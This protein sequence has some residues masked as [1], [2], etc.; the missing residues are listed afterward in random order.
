MMKKILPFTVVLLFFMGLCLVP[1]V[2]E[3]DFVQTI[4]EDQVSIP[5]EG[6]SRTIRVAVYNES[7]TTAPAW[8]T[9]PH[10][11]YDF[12]AT[13]A[14]L[15]SSGFDV[16]LL[17]TADILNHE[18]MTANYDVFVMIDNVPKD[19]IVDYVYEYW[20]GGGGILSFNSAFGYL[21][22]SGIFVPE[23]AGS[24][25]WTSHWLQWS[26]AFP[27]TPVNHTILARHSMGQSYHPG[28]KIPDVLTNTVVSNPAILGTSTGPEM[29][30]F[31]DGYTGTSYSAWALEPDTRAGGRVVQL[32]GNG[33]IVN[34]GWES[35][36]IDSVEWLAPKP[37]ARIVFDLLHQPRLG[38]DLWDTM[39]A[40]PGYMTDMRDLLEMSGYTVDKLYQKESGNLTLE[41]L[42]PYDMLII[43][44]P[45]RNFTASEITDIRSWIAAGGG[46]L[47]M[48]E[49]P[50]YT[51]FEEPSDQINWLMDDFDMELGP[52]MYVTSV[53]GSFAEHP[54]ADDCSTAPY[55]AVGFVNYS[56]DAFQITYEDSNTYSAGTEY[57]DGRAVLVADI[58]FGMNAE[59][60][61]GSN[62]QFVRNLANWLTAAEARVLYYTNEPTFGYGMT[63]GSLA[64]N[65]LGVDYYMVTDEG[66]MNMSLYMYSWDLVIL[67][68]PWNHINAYLDDVNNYLD[69]GGK[70]LWSYY[71]ATAGFT[72][73]I[74]S[75]IG[76]AVHDSVEDPDP[77]YI[78][79]SSHS[80]FNMPNN[81]NAANFTPTYDYGTEGD[82]LTV[83]S[84]AT[85]IAG[86]TATEEA[87]NATIVL[88]LNGRVLYNAFLI[89]EYQADFDDST[90]MDSFELWENEIAFMLRPTINHPADV[91]YE[92]GTTGNS[93]GWS[94]SSD[95]PRRYTIDQDSVQV[96]SGNWNGG[97]ISIDIDGLTNGTYAY[98]I[99]VFDN[100]G[101]SVSDIVN[102]H[103]T[104]APTTP[105]NTT[106]DGGGVPGNLTTLL[107]IVAAGGVVIII[108]IVLVM[109]KKK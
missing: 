42:S 32:P 53:I 44:S 4:Q 36:I 58:N 85:A 109:K 91:E 105:T 98:E 39:C 70:L 25:M 78:W 60:G 65:D 52:Y 33:S 63:P 82:Y 61:A 27:P 89:D 80:V 20:L 43:L 50:L 81:Y 93:I 107:I 9:N 83:F 56:G 38:V 1:P 17:T 14:F 69:T 100:A 2:G 28:D 87:G 24:D 11:T 77:T 16:T 46:L 7:D 96:D 55:S 57:G 104:V 74:W 103:V 48:G 15:T 49:S 95:R 51:S 8:S 19:N 12:A 86:Q 84:N 59:L 62:T 97:T 47:A 64:L 108:V 71:Y 6:V 3:V 34:P 68:A 5:S 30:V 73:P 99:T 37:K 90:Y 106:G 31:S 88:G 45:D 40:F 72:H 29:T 101:Y 18:L 35:V 41:R 79:E 54:I 66:S 75:R 21:F 67:D 13:T 23:W 22:Y 102:V 92:E 94:A 76:F 10:Y 26:T